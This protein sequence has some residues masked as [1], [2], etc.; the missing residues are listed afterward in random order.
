MNGIPNKGGRNGAGNGALAY[1]TVGSLNKYEV[2]NKSNK[3]F[4]CC[5]FEL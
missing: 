2:S 3:A 5:I 4:L 1:L